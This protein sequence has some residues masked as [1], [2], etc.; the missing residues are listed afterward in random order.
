MVQGPEERG[1][2]NENP[3][4]SRC[5]PSSALYITAVHHCTSSI[6]IKIMVIIFTKVNLLT[7]NRRNQIKLS[8]LV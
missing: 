1:Q 7:C 6:K 5:P 2:K 8:R 4:D 3:V